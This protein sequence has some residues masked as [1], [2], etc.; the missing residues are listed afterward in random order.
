MKKRTKLI[1]F[2][3]LS[4]LLT[5]CKEIIAKP[6]TLDNPLVDN[7]SH[8]I[9]NVFTKIYDNYRDSSGFKQLIFD[10]VLH[11]VAVD[12]F[13]EYEDLAE[14]SIFKAAVDER[15]KEKFYNEIKAASYQERSFFQEEQYI[16]EK[17]YGGQNRY[18]I[19]DDEKLTIKDVDA[20]DESAFY[21]EGLFLPAVDKTNFDEFEIVHYDYYSDYVVDSF[22][23]EVYREKLVE[24]YVVDEQ[25]HILG[26]N[27]ARK[28]SYI[29]LKDSNEH[30]NA[31]SNLVHAFID[32][33]IIKE[34]G[35]PDLNILANAWRGN[36]DDF[37][38]DGNEEDLLLKA[39]LIVKDG[40]GDRI[41]DHTLTGDVMT[42]FNK[43]KDDPMLTNLDAEIKFTGGNKYLKE[44]GLEIEL[45]EVRKKS[46]V[47]TEWGIKSGGITGLP[48]ALR[49]RVFNISTANGVDSV[50][51]DEGN[52]VDAG[53]MT[54]TAL[55]NTFVRNIHGTYYL[56]PKI[57]ER[58][59]NRNFLFYENDTYYIVQIE[60]AVN[61]AKLTEG[62]SDYYLGD[63]GKFVNDEDRFNK[64]IVSEIARIL[65]ALEATKTN[66]FTHY[67]EQLNVVFHDEEIQEFFA[68]KFPEIFGD[69]DE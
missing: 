25:S 45:N 52:I 34:D 27:Y 41:V 46:Y 23:K 69:D 55:R 11:L 12:K 9:N 15:I 39:G 63:D 62:N 21:T 66:A 65:A 35:D 32:E 40:A 2:L 61:T 29:A 28:V 17:V 59:D 47:T 13:G 20:L 30:P 56:T 43:I 51:D 8:E 1:A 67:L 7:L 58:N 44:D 26:R 19:V 49:N 68:S 54:G 37:K 60:E 10:E 53:K 24:Q 48:D 3:G 14:D 50:L 31:V 38:V 18:I 33:N 57:H 42:E 36:E 16:R 6:T 22:L 5:G 4:L 64:E